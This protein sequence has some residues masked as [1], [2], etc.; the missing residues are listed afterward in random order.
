MWR[1]LWQYLRALWKHFG[2]LATGAVVTVLLL[3]WQYALKQ[4]DIPLWV[5][6]TAVGAGLFIS[7]LQ[8]WREEH[9]KVADQADTER[10]EERRRLRA[11]ADKMVEEYVAWA[12][13]RHDAGP[14]ALA[15]LGLH[16]LKSDAL[17]REAIQEMYER[18]G[19]NPWSGYGHHVEDVDLVTFF[20][21]VREMNFDFLKDGTVEDVSKQVKA[22]GRY[23]S[24]TL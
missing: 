17:I 2:G 15:R 9:G 7:G 4:G 11:L 12:R 5:L 3:I 21:V 16:A 19:T 8:A 13:P 6:G 14:H 1:D 24:K 22:A 20:T 23:R 10:R 18:S